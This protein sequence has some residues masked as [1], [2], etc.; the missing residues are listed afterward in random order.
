MKKILPLFLL[1]LLGGSTQANNI[2]ISNVSVAGP[3]LSFTISWD[4]SWN[5]MSN[6]D[7]LYPNNWDGAWVF[8]KYQNNI[9]N[10]WKHAKLSTTS[11]DHVINGSVLQIDAVSDGMGVFIRRSNP[12]S[13][14]VTANVTLKMD[15]LIGTGTFNFKVFGVEMVYIP[16]GEFH[17]G[18]GPGGYNPTI[19]TI[20]A[21]KQ[22]GG[23]AP[24]LLFTS[25]PAVPATFPMGFTAF[26]NMKYEI[27]NEQWVDFLNTLNYDQQAVRTELAPNNA[28]GTKVYTQT[29]ALG[30]EHTVQI[31]TPG[32]NNTLPAVYACDFTDDDVFNSPNDGQN[33]PVTSIGR[34]DVLAYLDWAGLRPMTEMEF[35]K[36]CR[37]T[38][39]RVAAEYA[40]GS[41]E[42]VEYTRQ[43]HF[44]NTPGTATEALSSA[45]PV[46][47]GRTVSGSNIHAAAGPVRSGAFA[48]ATTGRAASGAGFWGTMEMTGN[49]W[50]TCIWL[51]ATGVTYTGNHGNGM[52]TTTGQADVAGWPPVNTNAGVGV[53]GGDWLSVVNRF[54]YLTLSGRGAGLMGTARH[55]TYGGRGCRTAP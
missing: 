26:Y 36:T 21:T 3:H 9:D 51:D 32:L 42:I 16:Q 19:A 45:L 54:S 43:T 4:N 2:Q 44:T 39:P 37:G 7:P 38:R 30:T 25:S 48:Q 29:S 8:I 47:N 33:I 35:E 12:G 1:L 13:G 5:T 11:A 49:I 14:N 41:T 18:D 6:I 50:E 52:L 23:I 17:W 46:V 20:D 40:W 10:L 24:G 53:R 28:V 31:Q 55:H 34:D 15:P 27:T 22:S